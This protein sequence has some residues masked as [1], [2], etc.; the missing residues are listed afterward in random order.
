MRTIQQ[1]F[2]FFL[3][4]SG[5][6]SVNILEMRRTQVS[7]LKRHNFLEKMMILISGLSSLS[8]IRGWL[9]LSIFIMK[10]SFHSSFQCSPHF[11]KFSWHVGMECYITSKHYFM[12]IFKFW[13]LPSYR[14][15]WGGND[16]LE[17][18]VWESIFLVYISTL[19]N[20]KLLIQNLGYVFVLVQ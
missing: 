6:S 8:S 18:R 9:N 2:V 10:N 4:L 13:A 11:L 17:G 3:S 14:R 5:I 16:R 1:F 19:A 20:I 15:I 12:V 7:V